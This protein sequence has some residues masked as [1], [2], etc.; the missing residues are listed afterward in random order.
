[1]KTPPHLGRQEENEMAKTVSICT[2]KNAAKI[3]VDGNEIHDV[4]S[5]VLEETTEGATL[6]LTIA[7]MGEGKAKQSKEDSEAEEQ[8]WNVK[9]QEMIEDWILSNTP[10]VC[11]ETVDRIW[12][13]V[14]IQV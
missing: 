9:R 12:E 5:Y 6:K 7:I 14:H 10:E 13:L 1:M 8:Y 3:V 4:I 11:K 2:E